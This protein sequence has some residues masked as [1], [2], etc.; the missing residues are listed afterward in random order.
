MRESLTYGPV[1]G[2]IGQPPA[3]PGQATAYSLRLAVLG[4]GFPPR[5]M[6]SVRLLPD[7]W[8]EETL[9]ILRSLG[10]LLPSK[11][12]PQGVGCTPDAISTA[13]TGVVI[14]GK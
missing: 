6:P 9:W 14:G 4:S 2:P 5:L 1:G 3:L 13:H 11:P 8:L 12:L 7:E 10:R